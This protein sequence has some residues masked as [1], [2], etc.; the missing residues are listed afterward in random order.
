VKIAKRATGIRKGRGYSLEIWNLVEKMFQTI[1]QRKNFNLWFKL[2]FH[3]AFQ[4]G[5]GRGRRKRAKEM[6]G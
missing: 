4:Q 2:S 6:M 1:L 3:R 5:L